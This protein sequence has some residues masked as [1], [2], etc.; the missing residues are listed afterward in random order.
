MKYGFVYCLGNKTF[1]GLY[2][3]GFTERSPLQRAEEISRGTGVPSEYFVI[4]YIECERPAQ[5]ERDIHQMLSR[6]RPNHC[7]EFFN[8]PLVEITAHFFHH[9]FA[10]S[11]VDK[12]AC[13]ET[14]TNPWLVDSPYEKAAS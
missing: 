2:K 5:V 10:M 1:P 13:P 11:W 4:C 3:I 6:Y 7:R 14:G 9:P 12:M 8:A